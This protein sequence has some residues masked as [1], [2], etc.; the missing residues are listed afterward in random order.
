MSRT[1]KIPLLIAFLLLLL[2][3]GTLAERRHHFLERNWFEF[4]QSLRDRAPEDSLWLPGYRVVTQALV[5]EGVDSD[6]SALTYDPDRNLLLS[7]T[8]KNTHL[9]EMDLA[10]RVLRRIPMR[11]FGDPEA[12]EYIGPGTF[13][14]TE[15]RN[16][17]LYRI[18][19]DDQ[20][21]VV[22]ASEGVQLS[23]GLNP[24]SNEGFEGSAFDPAAGRLYIAKER[25]PLS[26][27]EIDGFTNMGAMAARPGLHVRSDPDRDAALFLGDLSSLVF[28]PRTGHLL[29]L[30]DESRM[31]L[32][33][34]AAGRPLSSLS[35]DAGRHGLTDSVPQAEGVTMD[36][37]GNI[38]VISEPNLFYVFSREG[39]G[40]PGS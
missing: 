10:G 35:L 33:L 30:S 40:T 18:R 34:D 7:L 8:N 21:R 37:E 3:G 19:I 12:L 31:L 29:A 25:D 26:I 9:I 14:V 13:V 1:L 16:Q 38:Y 15:E 17:R 4:G 36:A 23:L 11:G 6:L 24:Q 39:N 20:T 27:L 22:E 5:I 28:D 32:E 2:V